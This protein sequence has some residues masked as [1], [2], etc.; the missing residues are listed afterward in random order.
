[1]VAAASRTSSSE[2]P[3]VLALAVLALGWLLIVWGA[4]AVPS[5]VTDAVCGLGL[6]LLWRAEPAKHSP[7][8]LIPNTLTA[9]E[10]LPFTRLQ[11]RG[12]T[13]LLVFG[14]GIVGG[15]LAGWCRNLLG[16]Y[17]WVVAVCCTALVLLSGWW[18]Y[19]IRREFMGLLER[20]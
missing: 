3:L 1:M 17:D 12:R 5:L 4:A 13:A 11:Q 10:R 2:R 14:V 7:D 20:P 16:P 8:N 15:L 19:R 9:Q 18:M 6:V